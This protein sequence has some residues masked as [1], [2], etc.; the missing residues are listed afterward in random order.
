MVKYLIRR[1]IYI[2]MVLFMV[3]FILFMLFRTMPGDPIEIYMPLE[4]QMGMRPEQLAE[5][6]A[7]IIETMGLDQPHVVQ[8][9]YWLSAMF[10]GN[11]GISMETRLPVQDH[12]SGPMA[13]TI[14]LNLFSMVLVLGITIPMGVYAAIKRGKTYDNTVLVVSMFGISIPGFLFALMLIVFLVIV[15]PWDIFPM[16]GMA[17]IMPPDAG[18]LAWYLDRLRFMLL[19]L[20]T[21]MLMSLAGMTRFVRSAMIDA[22]NM[23]CVRT[24]RAKGLAEKTVIYVH[25]FKNALIPIV[26]IMAGFFIGIFSGSIIIEVTFQWQGMGLTMLN[27][28]NRRDIG[29]LMTMNVFYALIAFTGIL[30]LD[31]VYAII[32]P[33][34]RF[35]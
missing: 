35:S 30:V 21:I 8:Y 1:V 9:F 26:T 5:M 31:I 11:F 4:M 23:D 32:D 33:R 28:L 16:F 2:I 18:T 7:E 13:N 20:L 6:R 27:A 17:S 14:V 10:R 15:P 25:A 3:S 34:I 29:V 19:P 12:I 22:L 24:A